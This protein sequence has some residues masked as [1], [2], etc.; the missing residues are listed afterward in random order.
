MQNGRFENECI[1]R[2]EI[3][4]FTGLKFFTIAP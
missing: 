1:L 4:L 2:K 3:T